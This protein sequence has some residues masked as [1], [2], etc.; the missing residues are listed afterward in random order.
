MHVFG[1]L[2]LVF[3]ELVDAPAMPRFVL[4]HVMRPVGAGLGFERG[5][6]RCEPRPEARE[7]FLEHMIACEPQPSL[8]HLHGDVAIP[9]VIRGTRQFPGRIAGHVHEDLR[10]RDD[11]DHAAVGGHEEVAAAQDVAAREVQRHFLATVER[12]ELARLLPLLEWQGEVRGDL[13]CVRGVG[14]DRKARADLD[15]QKRK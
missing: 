4:V 1:L 5:H 6:E 3:A 13:Q 9:E 12:G 15:H 11:L 14:T 7:H 8:A 2:V 10:L